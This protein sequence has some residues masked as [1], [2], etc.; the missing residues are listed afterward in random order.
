M[1]Y[2]INVPNFGEF[3]DPRS[4]ADLAHEAEAAGWDGFFVW[5]GLH[6]SYPA[7]AV[8]MTDVWIA[9]TAA[10]MTTQRMRLGPMLTPLARRRPWKVARE[11][12]ALDVLS[13]GRLILG[14]GLG[15]PPMEFSTFGEDADPRVRGDKL[16]EGL[17]VLTGLWSGKPFSF[18]GRYYTVRDAL[19]APPPLQQPRIPIWVG[20]TWPNRRPFRRA[21]R[22]DGVFPLL[23]GTF[24]SPSAD[25]LREVVAFVH[26]HRDAPARLEV[27]V[28]GSTPGGNAGRA[29]AIVAAY[30][31]A[32][33]T[34]WHE[35][36]DQGRRSLEDM[37]ARVR[38]GPPV[39]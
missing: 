37:R 4:L 28:G 8:P 1:K 29:A 25:Q 30:A 20:G 27:I 11:T 9:L 31:E 24:T 21:A 14:V 32:G 10:A 5:D 6:P 18:D 35:D 7:E 23:A 17:A 33:M 19:F 2:G 12:V 26:E 13:G 34:W 36:Y 39:A 15:E 16:D 3:G 38:Q 22:F